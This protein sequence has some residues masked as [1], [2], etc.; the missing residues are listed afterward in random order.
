[1]IEKL[2]L[3]GNKLLLLMI[4]SFI[5]TYLGGHDAIKS[6]T[7]YNSLD[8]KN[9]LIFKLTEKNNK[10]N[11]GQY[12]PDLIFIGELLTTGEQIEI[13]VSKG[14]FD[15]QSV[16]QVIKVYKSSSNIFMTKYEVDNQR[17]IH[18]GDIGFSF[19][20]FPTLIF[21]LIGLFSLYIILKK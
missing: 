9:D 5:V 18:L 14:D 12:F 8:L 6:T 11:E 16:G 19:V 17:M 2:K 21:F 15:N 1:M 7:L 13:K 3:Y 4:I 20:F 10:N